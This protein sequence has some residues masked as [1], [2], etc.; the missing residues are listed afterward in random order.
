MP[1]AQRKA[2]GEG[3]W[4][5]EQQ[6]QPFW[7]QAWLHVRHFFHGWG[8]GG[9]CSG[10]IQVQYIYHAFYFYYFSISSK[11]DHQALDPRGRSSLD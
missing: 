7:H 6:S 8:E 4:G 11:S 5:L 2:G 1:G 3:V 10:M 9:P